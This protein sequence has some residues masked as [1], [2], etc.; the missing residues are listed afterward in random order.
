V[1]E[2]L[3]QAWRNV[4]GVVAAAIASLGYLVPVAA[5]VWGLVLAGRR[6]RRQPA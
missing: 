5:L 1:R 4:V 6:W 2:A 3:R